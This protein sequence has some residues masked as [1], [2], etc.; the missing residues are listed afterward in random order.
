MAEAPDLSTRLRAAGLRVTSQRLLLHAALLD[1]GHH[2]TADEVMSAAAPRLPGLSL[3]TVY[4]TL[5]LLARLGLV[6]RVA[7]GAGAVRWDPG[8]EP[9]AH[10]SCTGCGALTDVPGVADAGLLERAAQRAGLTVDAV[11]VVLRGRC[12]ACVQNG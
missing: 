4:A 1:L 8:P 7:V 6:Q 10:F 3:P 2:A 5:E 12:A 11:D 9:H